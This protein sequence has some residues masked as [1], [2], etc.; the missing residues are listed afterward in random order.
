MPIVPKGCEPKKVLS[1]KQLQARIYNRRQ[2]LIRQNHELRSLKKKCFK[3]MIE[4][5]NEPARCKR[6]KKLKFGITK[7]AKH[8]NSR[9]VQSSFNNWKK[10]VESDDFLALKRKRQEEEAKLFAEEEEEM[11]RELELKRAKLKAAEIAAEE[12][13]KQRLENR[14]KKGS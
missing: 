7:M 9:V 13:E 2:E 11:K 5:F 6:R 14:G 4:D 3:K 1:A 10:L 12:E 8:R